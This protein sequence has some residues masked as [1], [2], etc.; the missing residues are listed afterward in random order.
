M[1][2]LGDTFPQIA[3][4]VKQWNRRRHKSHLWNSLDLHLSSLCKDAN[5]RHSRGKGT[6]K[7][8]KKRQRWM[9]FLSSSGF[10]S[11]EHKSFGAVAL[12]KKADFAVLWPKLY[13]QHAWQH[14]W[15]PNPS[16]VAA[17]G[18]R[19]LSQT[20]K[21]TSNWLWHAADSSVMHDVLMV[22]PQHCQQQVAAP[23]LVSDQGDARGLSTHGQLIWKAAKDCWSWHGR[24]STEPQWTVG[25]G[26][27]QCNNG[28][29][30]KSCY[31]EVLLSLHLKDE[32]VFL[33]LCQ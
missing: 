5:W 26:A 8:R 28:H 17:R 3:A 2:T 4:K 12:H 33:G 10:G 18:R 15:P 30:R 11:F 25:P 16:W 14:A 32:L 24:L 7:K 21:K 29:F 1:F 23:Q 20:Q 22:L 19:E 13:E 9:L 31:F 6:N 27:F